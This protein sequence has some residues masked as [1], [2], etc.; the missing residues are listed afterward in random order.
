MSDSRRCRRSSSTKR[1]L[2]GW[3]CRRG[4]AVL[5]PGRIGDAHQDQ[6]LI[7]LYVEDYP[8]ILKQYL[9]FIKSEWS[10]DSEGVRSRE[11][12]R[13]LLESEF[14]PDVVLHDCQILALNPITARQRSLAASCISFTTCL[15]SLIA[16]SCFRAVASFSARSRIFRDLPWASSANR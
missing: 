3:P 2:A 12:A 15:V 6:K 11:A 14:K 13:E 7:I 10:P 5:Q 9:E 8:R 1:E 16:L 4:R